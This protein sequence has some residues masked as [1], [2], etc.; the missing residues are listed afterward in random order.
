[1]PPRVMHANELNAHTSLELCIIL[2]RP[3]VYLPCD[4]AFKSDAL[5]VPKL[6]RAAAIPVSIVPSV[7][8]T[9]NNIMQLISVP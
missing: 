9:H 1:M 3:T 7:R 8:N 6:A 5:L 4:A 2:K